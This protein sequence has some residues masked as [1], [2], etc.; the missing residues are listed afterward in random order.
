MQ[1]PGGMSPA[2]TSDVLP[3][4]SCGLGTSHISKFY[5]KRVGFRD[6]WG[7]GTLKGIRSPNVGAGKLF[8]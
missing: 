7:D 5:L 8:L 3:Q 4:S 2:V 1:D 6:C